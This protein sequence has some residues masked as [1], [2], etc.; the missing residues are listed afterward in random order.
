MLDFLLE[1]G[2]ELGID[3]AI[4]GMAHRGRLNVLAN[5]LGNPTSRFSMNLKTNIRLTFLKGQEM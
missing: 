1:K 4:I 2:S 3:E 5:I